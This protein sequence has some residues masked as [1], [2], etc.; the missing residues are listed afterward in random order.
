M[1]GSAPGLEPVD[2]DGGGKGETELE[3]IPAHLPQSLSPSPVWTE[4][5]CGEHPD[6]ISHSQTHQPQFTSFLGTSIPNSC[7]PPLCA[8]CL[9]LSTKCHPLP[10][11][12]SSRLQVSEPGLPGFASSPAS[13]LPPS[14]LC[15]GHQRQGQSRP[16]PCVPISPQ[17]AP[18]PP[19][20]QQFPLWYSSFTHSQSLTHH[21][22][23]SSAVLHPSSQLPFGHLP[24]PYHSPDRWHPHNFSYF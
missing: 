24:H 6:I 21:K 1:L 3:H 7:H 4:G 19:Q 8:P 2:V 10:S 15:C 23:S 14:H 9:G 12:C 13:F 18:A 17:R 22:G 5:G 20:T 16:I 11:R